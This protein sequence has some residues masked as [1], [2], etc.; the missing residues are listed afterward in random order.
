VKREY[1]KYFKVTFPYLRRRKGLV[2]AMIGL[3]RE[4]LT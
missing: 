2:A 3:E 4:V 1:W